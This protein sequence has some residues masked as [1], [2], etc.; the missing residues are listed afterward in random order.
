MP[1]RKLTDVFLRGQRNYIQGTQIVCRA[2][3]FLGDPEAVLTEC[4]FS[5]ITEN[6]VSFSL[7]KPQSAIGS[8]GFISGAGDRKI[9]YVI[10]QGTPA[11]RN[12]APMHI[13]VVSYETSDTPDTAHC[14][15]RCHNNFE[16]ILNAIVQ[17]V[18]LHQ[19]ESYGDI[20]DNWFTGLRRVSL[21]LSLISEKS[22][23]SPD[24]EHIDF[25]IIIELERRF[26]GNEINNAIYKL[27]P[28]QTDANSPAK[29]YITFSYR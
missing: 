19:K 16:S 10:D 28:L 22:Q 24:N 23:P 15:V 3:E 21:P 18:K 4:K 2:A 6:L 26:S 29:G 13:E 5:D 1:D 20:T 7:D 8:V 25:S 9:V 27:S 17:A 11:K 14:H 12:D